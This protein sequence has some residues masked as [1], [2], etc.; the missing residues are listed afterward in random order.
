MFCPNCGMHKDL[1]VCGYYDKSNE[2]K[3]N[4]WELNKE[5]K[6]ESSPIIQHPKTNQS[7]QLKPENKELKNI[8]NQTKKFH[9]GSMKFKNY[10][11]G[12]LEFINLNSKINTKSDRP[13]FPFEGTYYTSEE[14][15]IQYYKSKG[16][17]AF[18]CENK[19]WRKL[20]KTHF[21]DIFKE[22]KKVC[23]QKGYR[24]GYY[25]NE[26]FTAC[27]DKINEKINYL[28]NIN[29][30]DEIKKQ[31]IKSELKNKILRICELLDT[32][33]ILS[34]MYFMLQDF[35]KRKRG[36]PDLF[37]FNDNEFFF[38]EVKAN[39]DVLS[40]Y[41]VRNH[42]K[43]LNTGID[44]CLFSIN[45]SETFLKEEKWK[46]FNEDFYDVNDYKEKYDFKIRTAHKIH[47][48]LENNNIDKIKTKFL[49]NYDLCTYMGFLNIMKDYPHDKKLKTI[50][51]IDEIII[52]QSKKEGIKIKN[53]YYLSK[54][55][56]LEKR[57]LYSQAIEE[58]K[59]AKDYY[60]Y[61]KLCVC[62][63]KRKDYENEVNLTYYV[64]NN[65]SGIPSDCKL[66]FKS[67]AQRFTKNKK[68]ISVYKTANKCPNCGSDE[69]VVVLNS[70]DNLKIRICNNG[71]CYWYGGVY[72]LNIE[73]LEEMTD[74]EDFNVDVNLKKSI[75]K[76]SN[77]QRR[78]KQK[79]LFKKTERPENDENYAKNL[80]IKYELILRGESLLNTENYNEAIT[81]Y[82]E[83]LNHEFFINDY[84]PF[85]MLTKSY[86]GL[87]QHDKEVEVI[88]EFFKSGRYCKKSVLK[89]FKKR[90]QE[91]D[92]IGYFDYS[93]INELENEF[94]NNGAKNLKLC[95]VPLTLAHEI[96]LSKKRLNQKPLKY[97]PDYFDS[98]VEFNNDLSYDEK[99]KFKYELMMKGKKLYKYYK[100]DKPIAFYTRLLSHKLFINDYYP[101][102]ELTRILHK[103]KRYD[104]E[105]ETIVKFFKSGIYCDKNQLIW[106]KKQLRRLSRYGYYDYSK[107]SSL[108][109]E[110][111]VNG[112]LKEDLSNQPVPPAN[113]IKKM[114]E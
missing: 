87:E 66:Y 24:S 61:Y 13:L 8:P 101:Y 79:S 10:S 41:Q 110:F 92:E 52:N 102:V 96:K 4:G 38:C 16:Y 99:V 77:R 21:K 71:S 85:V 1:C 91:L 35:N 12:N 47:K 111:D 40:A 105:V 114:Y 32:E 54:G 107:I 113:E 72:K 42:E 64:I 43:L 45:K 22:F 106:F 65:I 39:T 55:S 112:A 104:K 28:R 37:V 95:R 89:R 74:L 30:A 17:D 70:R 48:E 97:S 9:S 18:F 75:S 27:E 60:G 93:T 69:V 62:Y 86:K 67:R 44:V 3:S 34:I 76:F 59:N 53:L 83:L 84:Y 103:N 6:I 57:G 33:Q 36:F 78:N 20:L 26:H 108:E 94:R 58:Y 29:L 98:D 109:Y 2:S 100:Y 49:S 90:L 51:N 31:K 82:N 5:V 68:R 81:F 15:A 7:F 19:P 25:D 63:R 50:D 88:T 46:Y 80:E 23:K 56:Y 73:D 14:F 11:Q